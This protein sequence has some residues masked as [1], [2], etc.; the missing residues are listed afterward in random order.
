MQTNL[1]EYMYVTLN[2]RDDLVAEPVAGYNE[3]K[4]FTTVA[5]WQDDCKLK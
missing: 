4:D 2:L 5:A 1:R 3:D